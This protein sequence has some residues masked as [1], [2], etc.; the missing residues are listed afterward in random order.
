MNKSKISVIVPAYNAENMIENCIQSIL[1]Q[2]Y[3]NLEIVIV[4]D[5]STDGTLDI[6]KGLS[7]KDSR[8]KIVDIKNG[9]VSHARNTGIDIATGSYITFV[10]SDDTIE[11]D[12][13]EYLINL[14]EKYSVDIAHCSYANID[15]Y[16][17]RRVVGDTGRE[18]LQNHDEALKCLVS[19]RLF[20]GGLCNKLYKIKLFDDVRLDETIKFNE[21][22]LINYELFD[23]AKTSVYSDRAL[24]DYYA[25][26]E[27]STHSSDPVIVTKQ[28]NYVSQII[29]QRSKGKTFE[30]EAKRR[31][32]YSTMVM[33]RAYLYSK[34]MSKEDKIEVKSKLKEY[35][36]HNLFIGRKENIGV[37]MMLYVPIF[38]KIFYKFYDK[39]RVKK[40]DPEQ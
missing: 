14:I 29:Y 20:I 35:F 21:D 2:T 23:K 28:G 6:L 38:Y 3:R 36:K 7:N 11:P 17:N 32:A 31:L 18:I 40:L 25:N 1:N 19:G 34:S 15:K 9:G 30:R 16:G 5:G 12:M 37:W 13:Y 22:I 26:D 10:D 24:Y 39:I 8:I 33:Y 4:N 27:S